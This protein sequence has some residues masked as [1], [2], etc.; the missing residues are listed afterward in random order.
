MKRWI[1]KITKQRK[2]PLIMIAVGFAGFLDYFYH[3]WV[4]LTGLQPT[5]ETAWVMAGATG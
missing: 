4:Y 1:S 3:G 2:I 5:V